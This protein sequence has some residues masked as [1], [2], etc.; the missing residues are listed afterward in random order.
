[1]GIRYFFPC[2]EA[3]H[4]VVGFVPSYDV[5]IIYFTV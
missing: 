4:K 3:N 1:M 5:R 2:T